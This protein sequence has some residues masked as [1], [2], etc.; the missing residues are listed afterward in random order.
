MLCV[1]EACSLLRCVGVTLPRRVTGSLRRHAD[2][3]E[4]K[5]E[6]GSTS[7]AGQVCSERRQRWGSTTAVPQGIPLQMNGKRCILTA[8]PDLERMHL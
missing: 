7:G 4:Q 8:A 5:V 3:G 2:C 1:I 6:Q